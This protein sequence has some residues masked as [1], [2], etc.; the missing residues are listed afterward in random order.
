METHDLEVAFKTHEAQC[1]ERWK[2]IFAR[3]EDN[4]MF[5]Q[6]IENRMIAIGGTII[7]FLLGILFE[8]MQLLGG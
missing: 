7:L 2:T 1:E 6:R 8:G 3:V 4:S 5:L